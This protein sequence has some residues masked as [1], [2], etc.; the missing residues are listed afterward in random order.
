MHPERV[1]GLFSSS[2]SESSIKAVL[3]HYHI[4]ARMHV[5]KAWENFDETRPVAMLYSLMKPPVTAVFKLASCV[6]CRSVAEYQ[7]MAVV[8]FAGNGPAC[9]EMLHPCSSG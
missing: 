3:A 2:V 6:F 4:V 1:V 5:L 9:C 7:H 8:S